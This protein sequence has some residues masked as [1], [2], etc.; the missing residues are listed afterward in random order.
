MQCSRSD[1]NAEESRVQKGPSQMVIDKAT[2]ERIQCGDKTESV[3]DVND[4]MLH[5]DV[6]SLV[7]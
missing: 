1:G 7:R 2:V 3:G 5:C 6:N 4:I